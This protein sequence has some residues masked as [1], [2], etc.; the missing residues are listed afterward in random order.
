MDSR[1][2]D[3]CREKILT[4]TLL[5]LILAFVIVVGVAS[6]SWRMQ[7]LVREAR[8]QTEV[9]GMIAEKLGVSSRDL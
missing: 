2:S 6:I 9:L 5:G 7:A 1:S 8:V 4:M 3:Q